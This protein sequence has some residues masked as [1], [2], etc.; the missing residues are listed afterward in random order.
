MDKWFDN[1]K[2]SVW[3]NIKMSE[4]NKNVWIKEQIGVKG[5]GEGWLDDKIVN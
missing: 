1:D 5:W 2:M 3:K 4:G